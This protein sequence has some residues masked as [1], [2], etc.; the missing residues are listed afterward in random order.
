MNQNEQLLVEA[1]ESGEY[2]QGK[3]RLA[4]QS[5]NGWLYCCLGVACEVALKN[6][7]ELKI[8]Q[9]PYYKDSTHTTI[10][11]EKK[12]YDGHTTDL[13]APVQNWL[14]WND[15]NGTVRTGIIQPRGLECKTLIG[16]NDNGATFQEI[17]AIIRQDGIL[18]KEVV[19][20]EQA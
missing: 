13:P 1:L 15:D 14:G 19:N 10:V 4:T 7:V 6:G 5:D 2:E 16:I 9:R 17:A 12:S 11:N 8:E 20:A 18:K 3:H